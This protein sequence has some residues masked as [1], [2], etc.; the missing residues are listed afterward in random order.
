MKYRKGENVPFTKWRFGIRAVN[1]M[2]LDQC[3][4]F[5]CYKY[6]DSSESGLEANVCSLSEGF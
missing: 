1:S 6:K 2:F 4:M 5:D 3:F